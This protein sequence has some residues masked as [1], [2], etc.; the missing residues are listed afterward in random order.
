MSE[1]LQPVGKIYR[2][3][4]EE[5]YERLRTY[6]EKGNKFKCRENRIKEMSV[7]QTPS[8][9]IVEL[10]FEDG[11]VQLLMNEVLFKYLKKIYGMSFD[12]YRLDQ[13]AKMVYLMTIEN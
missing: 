6:L 10:S 7:E 3:S 2:Q 13:Y 9:H 11:R 1:T 4:Y 8:S 12:L 5:F